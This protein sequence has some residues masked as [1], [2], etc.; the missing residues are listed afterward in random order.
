[1]INDPVLFGEMMKDLP[2][3]K[4]AHYEQLQKKSPA[5]RSYY[6]RLYK[7]Q[8]SAAHSNIR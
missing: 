4:K 6:D 8:N 5:I 1:M 3:E 2:A 7:M